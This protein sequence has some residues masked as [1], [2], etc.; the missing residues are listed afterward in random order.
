MH[1]AF[2]HQ[3]YR[4]LRQALAL[5]GAF[6]LYAP[7]GEPV[8]FSKHKSFGTM[9][10]IRAWADEAL[11]Q[12]LL[13]IVARQISDVLTACDVFDGL[14][15]ARLGRLRRRRLARLARDEWEILDADQRPL[16]KLREASL[17]QASLRR[18]PSGSFLPQKYNL[19]LGAARAADLRQRFNP[20][21]YELNL[22]FTMDAGDRLDRRL[23]IA[24]GLLLG[25]MAGKPE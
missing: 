4:L 25:V 17:A 1:V 21:H 18:L 7:G 14:S 6:R 10:D 23:G 3:R 11:T 9:V 15:G 13:R 12:E 19:W 2:Q 24:A 20:L 8:I 5:T 22:D 16:G